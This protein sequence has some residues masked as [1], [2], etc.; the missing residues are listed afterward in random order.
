MMETFTVVLEPENFFFLSNRDTIIFPITFNI[1]ATYTFFW[2]AHTV[3]GRPILS[4]YSQI[5]LLHLMEN[6]ALPPPKVSGKD[7]TKMRKKERKYKHNFLSGKS[8]LL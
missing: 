7:V 1:S 6:K 8:M 5:R 4:S 3:E 2:S